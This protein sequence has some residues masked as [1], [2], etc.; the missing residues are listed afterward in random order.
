MVYSVTLID[1]KQGQ[2]FVKGGFYEITKTGKVQTKDEVAVLQDTASD[3]T[4]LVI[5][6]KVTAVGDTAGATGIYLTDSIDNDILIGK[7]GHVSGYEGVGG[8]ASHS[9]ITNRGEISAADNAIF[10]NGKNNTVINHGDIHSFNTAVGLAAGNGKVI[11]AGEI[12]G[13]TAIF[14]S[15]P[16]DSMSEIQNS[17]TITGSQ[18]AIFGSSGKDKVTNSGVINGD[19]SLYDGD[20]S[21]I[22]SAGK[23]NGSVYGGGGD[24]LYSLRK[25]GTKLVE[26]AGEGID[27]VHVSFDYKLRSNFED[28]Y[29]DGDKFVRGIGNELDNK[30]VGTGKGDNVLKGGGGHDI[31][32]G[33]F[34]NDVLVG[35]ARTDTFVFGDN[36]GRD[37][38]K[39]F[40]APG[41]KGHDMVDL[42]GTDNFSGF[43]EMKAHMKQ[44]GDDVV[45]N[46][47]EGNR[48]T[49]ENVQMDD[50]QEYHFMF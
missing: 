46:F 27:S 5:R 28:L 26:L 43:D 19:I 22:L 2:L 16:S 23:V 13:K 3:A 40:Q 30:L 15:E 29:L 49:L 45:I 18:W 25:G 24:D 1:D 32:D 21:F 38:I 35:G 17:G 37:R 12:S 36:Y 44:A 4:R 14:M 8:Y 42:G 33:A 11:N 47:G 31:L 50:L 10:L 41:M 7:A 48:L 34:G 9:L 20:D 6:G 39:D